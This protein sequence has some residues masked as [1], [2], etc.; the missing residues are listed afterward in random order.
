MDIKEALVSKEILEKG[1]M[2]QDF[3]YYLQ[4]IKGQ[5]ITGNYYIADSHDLKK[6]GIN[7]LKAVIMEF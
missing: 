4:Q 2:P 3:E 7:E 5:I 1:F 6:W